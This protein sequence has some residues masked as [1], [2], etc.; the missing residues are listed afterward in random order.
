MQREFEIRLDGDP[1][2][3]EPVAATLALLGELRG[4]VR[5]THLLYW[6]VRCYGAI[7]DALGIPPEKDGVRYAPFG[8]LAESWQTSLDEGL[9]DGRQGVRAGGRGDAEAGVQGWP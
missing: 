1:L 9:H 4:D 3:L 2:L 5:H 8:R 7:R 6:C